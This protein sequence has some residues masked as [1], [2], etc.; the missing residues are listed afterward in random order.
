MD[1]SSN[2]Q[3]SSLKENQEVFSF[4]TM[5]TEFI[6]IIDGL[7]EAYK[8]SLY[9]DQHIEEHIK[10]NN[11]D[12]ST[13]L[14]DELKRPEYKQIDNFIINILKVSWVMNNLKSSEVIVEAHWYIDTHKNND[15]TFDRESFS[16]YFDIYLNE[17]YIQ[18]YLL[19]MFYVKKVT[20][21]PEI[22]KKELETELSSLTDWFISKYQEYFSIDLF[23]NIFVTH[24][25]SE[26]NTDIIKWKKN[27]ISNQIALRIDFDRI[28]GFD[29][30]SHYN[31]QL[32]RSM[33]EWEIDKLLSY[34]ENLLWYVIFQIFKQKV[35]KLENSDHLIYF[36]EVLQS[37]KIFTNTITWVEIDNFLFNHREQLNEGMY[38]KLIDSDKWEEI[39]QEIIS[40]PGNSTR[41]MNTIIF[42]M[43]HFEEKYESYMPK[44]LEVY[45]SW[46]IDKKWIS[47]SYFWIWCSIDDLIIIYKY[48][49]ENKAKINPELDVEWVFENYRELFK[50]EDFKGELNQLYNWDLP[51]SYIKIAFS[52]FVKQI[53]DIQDTIDVEAWLYDGWVINVLLSNNDHWFPEQIDL[54]NDEI[55]NL[56]EL[57]YDSQDGLKMT[58]F[59]KR[60]TFLIR[61]ILYSELNQ[62]I[63][64]DDEKISE[65]LTKNYIR[66][67]EELLPMMRKLLW[68]PEEEKF[69]FSNYNNICL[70]VEVDNDEEEWCTTKDSKWDEIPF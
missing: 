59:I 28:K 45:I 50:A 34:D 13:F 66:S 47:D 15:N 39:L 31:I 2:S 58:D 44:L 56:I 10:N 11:K 63:Y 12:Y 32:E 43:E 48:Y 16:K 5:K 46:M 35:L 19:L 14:D 23:K 40:N 9:S 65:S 36:V 29:N 6:S 24:S 69:D 25:T 4:E 52:W 26:E 42:V 1:N 38:F 30:N 7:L 68:F 54:S 53:L 57:G 49:K 55:N 64:W 21:I 3:S 8:N 51:V 18:H 22:E 61:K 33:C 41:K 62:R 37:T 20:S 27:Y 17:V 67:K 70:D 60:Y